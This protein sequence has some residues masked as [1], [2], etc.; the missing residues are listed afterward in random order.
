MSWKSLMKSQNQTVDLSNEEKI[1]KEQARHPTRVPAVNIYETDEAI[2][3]VADMPGVTQDKVDI[4]IEQD[5]L[6]MRGMATPDKHDGF[7]QLH[8]EYEVAN[9]ERS[10]TVPSEI[11][12]QNV[13]ATIKQGVLSVVLQKQ[14]EPKPRKVAVKSN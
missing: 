9:F 13:V 7:R 14:N 8:R 11:D 6:T 4:T 1:D 3:V 5:V 2:I 12:A 10:F